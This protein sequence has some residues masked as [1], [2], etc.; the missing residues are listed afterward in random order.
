[1]KIVIV[2][3]IIIAIVAIVQKYR[4]KKRLINI[5]I[6][7]YG[8]FSYREIDFNMF[9]NLNKHYKSKDKKVCIDDITYN[10][11]DFIEVYKSMDNSSSG[12]GSEYLMTALRDTGIEEDKVKLRDSLANYFD[13]NEMK[14]VDAQIKIS[15]IGRFKNSSIFNNIETIA[16]YINNSNLFEYV[17]LFSLIVSTIIAI[18]FE[19]YAIILIF[20]IMISVG[21][22]LL[23]RSSIKEHLLT[24][25]MI[26]N[27]QQSLNKVYKSNKEAL[28]L[29]ENDIRDINKNI[30]LVKMAVLINENN[31]DIVSMI[32]DY[33]YMVI[34]VD[35]IVS[36]IISK[37]LQNNLESIKKMYE[38]IG[39]I[40]LAINI[41]SYRNALAYYARPEFNEDKQIEVEDVYHPLIDNAVP[42]SIDTNKSI[43]ITGSNASGKSTFLKT[44][45]ISSILA[46]TIYTV[47][48]KKYKACKFDI[49]SSM[50]IRD[51][52]F[53]KES[54][55]IVEIKSLNRIVK[56]K[57]EL[58]VLC[59]ID[60]ILR[61]TNTIER[62]AASNVILENMANGN[63]LC[64]AATHDI[65]LTR[66]L[67][68]V[69]KNYHFEETVVEDDI[70]FDYK[71]KGGASTTRNAIKLLKI[72][73]F[74][75]D[76]IEKAN[77]QVDILENGNA[78][79]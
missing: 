46:Q 9:N 29:Y 44:L 2:I 42:N 55:Y 22:Y 75:D 35:I 32:L 72:I 33:I 59:F 5:L 24:F 53:E 3:L 8:T 50:A 67:E 56:K 48:A 36:N 15:S 20:N 79:I 73:G 28:K 12:I 23:K 30:R 52:L 74:S 25:K 60:E 27:M 7:N 68:N 65:E 70:Q 58:P 76:I 47:P 1:M 14:R 16:D 41:A 61:G 49:M 51:N 19:K 40:E 21:A 66:L 34:H 18:N 69:Y 78:C 26:I 62:I 63:C 17:L 45:A 57:K 10:D 38:I 77:K 37:K 43:I 6:E 13:D 31:G 64:F 54:Y 4:Y 39:E 11:I 71:L